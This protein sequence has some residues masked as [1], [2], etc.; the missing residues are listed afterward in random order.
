MKRMN[1]AFQPQHMNTTTLAFLGDA[2]YETYVRLYIIGRMQAGAD[3]LHRAAVKYVRAESQAEAVKQLLDSLSEEELSLV[4]RAR[5]KRSAT[6]PKNADPV[7]YKWATAFEALIGYLYLAGN[8]ERM[9]EIINAAMESIKP[10]NEK[11]KDQK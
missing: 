7:S 3:R 11:E 10:D 4:K 1:T 9:E 5:N 6:K 8:K 2:I